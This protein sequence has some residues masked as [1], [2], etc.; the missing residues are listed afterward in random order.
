MRSFLV[1]FAVGLVAL[2]AV[3]LTQRSGLV[4]SLGVSPSLQAAQLNR[5]KPA[6]QGPIR[7]PHGEAFDR[8]GF[9]LTAPTDKPPVRVEVRE[10]DGGRVL[11]RGR[12]SAGAYENFVPLHPHENVIDVGRIQTTRALE[13]CVI[14]EGD[15]AV[16]A[17]GQAGIASPGTSATIGGKRVSPDIA[18]TLHTGDRSLLALL[19]DM[20]KR[21]AVFRAG[22]VTPG[23]YLVLALLILVGAPFVLARGLARATHEDAD[24][25][26]S[27]ASTTAQ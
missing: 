27:T 4:Y 14:N 15:T 19:P 10:A 18:F 5:G 8:V 23:V 3:A 1:V 24:Q 9:L 17:I 25:V 13:L 26:R 12:L 21:A 11:G 7:V 6:C 16:V 2:V 22:W 20:A